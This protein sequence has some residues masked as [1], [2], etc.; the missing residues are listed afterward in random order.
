MLTSAKTHF[1][2]GKPKL[3]RQEQHQRQ[4][5]AKTK[6]DR[7]KKNAKNERRAEKRFRQRKPHEPSRQESMRVTSDPD[8]PKLYWMGPDGR[9]HAELNLS[10][11]ELI[12][13]FN[14]RKATP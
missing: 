11:E 6:Y 9:L 1:K 13:R 12:E 4:K 10:A 2:N 3:T 7:E 14:Q 8:H 5:A